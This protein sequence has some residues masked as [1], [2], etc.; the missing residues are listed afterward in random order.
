[1]TLTD[2]QKNSA[3]RIDVRATE[4]WWS[5]Y[6]TQ[7]TLS[8]YPS[9]DSPVYGDVCQRFMG[10][11]WF[12]AS[13]IAVTLR[14]EGAQHIKNHL[15]DTGDEWVYGKLYDSG[16]K[17]HLMRARKQY[18]WVSDKATG[19]GMLTE[20]S[21]LWACMLQVFAS[22]FQIDRDNPKKIIYDSKNASLNRLN[23]GRAETGLRILT[24]KKAEAEGLTQGWYVRLLGRHISGYPMAI[25]SKGAATLQQLFPGQQFTA[26]NHSLVNGVVGGHM[27]GIWEVGKH[28]FG[29]VQK[30]N[31]PVNAIRIVNPWGWYKQ[32]WTPNLANPGRYFQPAVTSVMGQGDF[33]IPASIAPDFFQ[34]TF[35]AEQPLG[36]PA[37]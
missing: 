15:H 8:L 14:K 17:P 9:P 3:E 33:W 36:Q 24:G 30:D 16:D 2:E 31:P 37:N 25:G 6:E 10:N 19:K 20:T 28:Q 13:M 18:C 21:A 7:K 29:P 23:S 22:A 11:C 32:T 5:R 35:Y 1:M 4:K 26:Q 12:L 34:E 27:Y